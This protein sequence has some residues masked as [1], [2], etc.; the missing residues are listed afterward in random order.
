MLSVVNAINWFIP[1]VNA[2]LFHCN[3][4]T[5]FGKK[6]VP[7]HD[8]IFHKIIFEKDKVY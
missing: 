4:I 8:R 7:N 2:F 6:I 3:F 1:S 5:I